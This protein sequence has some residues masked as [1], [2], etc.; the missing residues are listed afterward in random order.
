MVYDLFSAFMSHSTAGRTP[1]SDVLAPSIPPSSAP[2]PAPRPRIRA[3]DAMKRFPTTTSSIPI[4]PTSTFLPSPAPHRLDSNS[5]PPAP[6]S[7]IPPTQLH[8]GPHGTRLR[9]LD[10][11]KSMSSTARPPP[12]PEPSHS[13]RKSVV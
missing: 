1:R 12:A 2:P 7:S 3:I 10:L 8:L 5:L 4:P 9:A 6:A 11:L 13:D